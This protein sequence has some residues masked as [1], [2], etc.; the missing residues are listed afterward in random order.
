MPTANYVASM[1][2]YCVWKNPPL[3]KIYLRF[4][5][6]LYPSS[7]MESFLK[8]KLI[9]TATKYPVYKQ[10]TPISCENI[11]TFVGK[12]S[13]SKLSKMLLASKRWKCV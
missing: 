10:Y 4:E 2:N 12:F 3:I 6:L 5:G 13:L 9:F 7:E 11:G 8:Q 1:K